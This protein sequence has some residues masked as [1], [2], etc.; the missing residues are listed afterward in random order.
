MI[1]MSSFQMT[2]Y[3]SNGL[4]KLVG[5]MALNVPSAVQMM[6]KKE[7]RENHSFIVIAPVAVNF[8]SKQIPSGITRG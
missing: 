5:K 3:L 6:C 1:C 2:N 4:Y 8:Q 7:R